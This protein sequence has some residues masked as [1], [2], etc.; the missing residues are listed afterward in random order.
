MQTIGIVLAG[1]LSRRYGSPKALAQH[2]HKYYYELAYEALE[3]TC[4]SVV[5]VGR[6]EFRHLLTKADQIMLDTP[7]FAGF[8]PLAGLYSVMDAYE[9]DQYMILPCDMPY[10]RSEMMNAL[11]AAYNGEDVLAVECDG[12]YHP[13]VAVYSSRM[14]PMIRAALEQGRFGVMRLLSEVQVRWID[15]MKLVS[16]IEGSVQVFINV[17]SPLELQ[18]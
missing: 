11:L 17:N 18:Q 15:G 1:G 3:G 9:A 13:L 2:D 4:H 16:E 7:E 12:H 5:V 10:I 8:G 6:P 14:K